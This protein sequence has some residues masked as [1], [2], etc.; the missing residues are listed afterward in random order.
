MK[1]PKNMFTCHDASSGLL[2][3]ALIRRK[4]PE[5]DVTL[6]NKDT[7]CQYFAVWHR[8]RNGYL[9]LQLLKYLC[10]HRV[11]ASMLIL[12]DQLCFP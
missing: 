8:P 9:Y 1:P 12:I 5:Q 4:S 7:I 10:V 2:A 6:K 3:D 11:Q